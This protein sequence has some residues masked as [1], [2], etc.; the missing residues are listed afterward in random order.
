MNPIEVD[1][2]LGRGWARIFESTPTDNFWTV[3]LNGS[4]AFVTFRQKEIRATRNFTYGRDMTAEELGRY[5]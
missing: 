5:L 1:T 4:R 3:E 2:A